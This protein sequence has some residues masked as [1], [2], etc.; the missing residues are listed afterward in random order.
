MAPARAAPIIGML[1]TLMKIRLNSPHVADDLVDA[2]LAE[3]CLAARTGDDTCEVL[4]PWV[5]TKA[6]AVQAWMELVFFL[7]AWA[8]GHP[9]L[10]TVL[11]A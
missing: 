9:G 10:E 5:E 4:F 3:D 1:T 8:H 6:D 11:S 2:L 7:K